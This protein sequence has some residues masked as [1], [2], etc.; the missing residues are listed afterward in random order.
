MGEQVYQVVMQYKVTAT[1]EQIG[2][3]REQ[4]ERS[5]PWLN[6]DDDGH[7]VRAIALTWAAG[8]ET[9]CTIEPLQPKVKRIK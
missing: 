9:P 4:L 3:W 1:P 8:S 6:W 5:V 2:C 7:V